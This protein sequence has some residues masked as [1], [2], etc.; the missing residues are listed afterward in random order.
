MRK[1]PPPCYSQFLS[2]IKNI[3]LNSILFQQR[4]AA[5]EKKLHSVQLFPLQAQ[6]IITKTSPLLFQPAIKVYIEH[7]IK[8][9]HFP[10]ASD[11]K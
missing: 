3:S 11:V 4:V 6:L 9:F 10:N 2:Y 8:F 1:I 5:V 7:K